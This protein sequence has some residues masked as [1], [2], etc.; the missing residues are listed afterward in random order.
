MVLQGS[1][2]GGAGSI[3]LRQLQG[4]YH[5]GVRHQARGIHTHRHISSVAEALHADVVDSGITRNIHRHTVIR[6]RATRIR[7]IHQDP[8][9]VYLHICQCGII[10]DAAQGVR[11]VEEMATEVVARNDTQL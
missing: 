6:T 7:R 3:P 2:T 5:H 10:M 8:A 9:G 1:T 11:D 4:C